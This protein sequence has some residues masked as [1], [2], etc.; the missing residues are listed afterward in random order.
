MINQRLMM[1]CAFV[2]VC[3][4]PVSCASWKPVSRYSQ[5][6]ICPE[7]VY[8]FKYAGTE[9]T[10]VHRY[11]VTNTGN[12]PV[13]IK[14]ITTDCGC[15]AALSTEQTVEPGKTAW[16]DVRFTT[17]RYEGKQNKHITVAAQNPQLPDLELSIIGTV[18]RDVAVWPMGID[19]GSIDQGRN[20]DRQITLYQVSQE[21][22]ILKRVEADERLYT[23]RSTP[24]DDENAKGFIITVTLKKDV[25][26]GK[27]EDVI[28]LHTNARRKPR[29]DVMV[30]ADI[31]ETVNNLKLKGRSTP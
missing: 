5:G 7:P 19:F 17:P 6:L 15:T 22:L 28:T 27:I 14:S 4:L 3:I 18:K 8:D 9:Q 16:I 10:L 26:I 25:P 12:Q 2:L 11:P 21:P 29:L 31:N 23:I 24:F 13:R 30:R 20:T 1:F